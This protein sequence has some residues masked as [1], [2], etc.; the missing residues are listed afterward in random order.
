MPPVSSPRVLDNSNA[1]PFQYPR[2]EQGFDESSSGGI[3]INS[4]NKNVSS[5]LN[6]DLPTPRLLP[7]HHMRFPAV[8]VTNFSTIL[9]SPQP[10]PGAVFTL[11]G[12]FGG[13]SL[14]RRAAL[15]AANGTTRSPQAE[16]EFPRSPC[17]RV[18]LLRCSHRRHG[19]HLTYPTS[20]E[21]TVDGGVSDDTRWRARSW[22]PGTKGNRKV[23]GG[24][25][26]V[27]NLGK[28]VFSGRKYKSYKVYAEFST[29][30]Y[31]T[32]LR[33]IMS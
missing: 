21:R 11:F 17:V 23:A 29:I 24:R 27:W 30:L 6:I 26:V 32:L 13:V 5:E 18:W 19:S 33:G 15:P 20:W 4:S 16:R 8:R 12:T 14:R 25:C 10:P 28:L 3:S 2:V 7:D 31:H 9:N 1:I 22:V